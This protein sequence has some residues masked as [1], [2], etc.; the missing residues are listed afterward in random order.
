VGPRVLHFDGYLVA[1]AGLVRTEAE[2]SLD[3]P[4]AARPDLHLGLG[5]RLF[6]GQRWLVRLEYRQYLYVR[7]EDRSGQGGGI[8]VASELALCGGVL[9]GGRR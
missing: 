6:F 1:G 8:G 5:L 9:L 7:P 3:L 4:A 2:E